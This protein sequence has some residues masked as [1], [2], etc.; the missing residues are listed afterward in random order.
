MDSYISVT[1]VNQYQHYKQRC[2][3]WVKL[4]GVILDNYDFTR[5]QD[6]SK[7]LAIGLTLLASKLDN[8]IPY[9]LA[10]IKSR[11]SMN[12]EPDIKSLVD[13][14][15]ITIVQDASKTL[16]TDASTLLA[17][18][19]SQESRVEKRREEADKPKDDWD[20]IVLKAGLKKDVVPKPI[21]YPD[22][23]KSFCNRYGKGGVRSTAYKYW[24]SLH[25]VDKVL[26]ETNVVGY[27][28]MLKRDTWRSKK[29]I[30]GWL[31]PKNRLFE[32]EYEGDAPSVFGS[33]QPPELTA[34]QK[35][36]ILDL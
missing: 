17:S 20:S 23:F 31:N 18:C 19:I 27:L 24:K 13:T 25:E 14:G 7:W 15:F 36:E 21:E 33:E 30:Q 2:P 5:L 9:D 32:A 35:A 16:A 6:A 12:S 22:R 28:A 29:D 8:K 11:L 4:H 3:P 10:F 1:N 34:E 26:C